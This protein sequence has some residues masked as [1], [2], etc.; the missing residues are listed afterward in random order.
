MAIS[1]C[2]D[3][4]LKTS[5]W[6]A[7]LRGLC[8]EPNQLDSYMMHVALALV[9]PHVAKK[10][11]DHDAGVVLSAAAMPYFTRYFRGTREQ[12]LAADSLAKSVDMQER[13]AQGSSSVARSQDYCTYVDSMIWAFLIADDMEGLK[14]R[15]AQNLQYELVRLE[16]EFERTLKLGS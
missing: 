9:T 7:T 4:W 15:S 5:P 10:F 8:D 13:M 14:A 11:G 16:G 2:I 3:D 6:F 1:D 12:E